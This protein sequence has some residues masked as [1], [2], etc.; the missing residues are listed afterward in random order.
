MTASRPVVVPAGMQS[1]VVMIGALA[2]VLVFLVVT[3][4]PAAHAEVAGRASVVDGDT[5]VIHGQR[6]EATAG[7]AGDCRIKGN[8]GSKGE[9][10]YHVPGGRFYERTRI[11]S[12]K[13]ERWFCSEAEAHAAGWRKSVP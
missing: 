2:S 1:N 9:R 8:I 10:V 13:G 5:I 3:L 11:D 6:V 7:E 12:S 4:A